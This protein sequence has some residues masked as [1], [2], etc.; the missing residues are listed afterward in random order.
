MQTITSP[1]TTATQGVVVRS[2]VKAGIGG[3]NHAEGVV[4]RSAVKAGRLSLNHSEEPVKP[5]PTTTEP[6]EDD[7]LVIEE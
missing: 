5:P 6:V 4:V 2:A 3:I 7:G 1:T